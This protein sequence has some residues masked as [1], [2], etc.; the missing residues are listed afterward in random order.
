MAKHI[1]TLDVQLALH[2]GVKDIIKGKLYPSS[3]EEGVYELSPAYLPVAFRYQC[4]GY[5]LIVKLSHQFMVGIETPEEL[6]EKVIQLVTDFFGISTDDII[7]YQVIKTPISKLRVKCNS[8]KEITRILGGKPVLQDL[9]E[10]NRIEYCNN[11]KML[12]PDVEKLIVADIFRIAP[13]TSRGATKGL[14]KYPNRVNCT[15]ATDNNT[16]VAITCYFK[17]YERLEDGDLEGAEKYK[18][19]LRSEVKL[20]NAHLNYMKG[21]RDKTL[22]NYFKEDVAQEYFTKYLAPIFSTEP[23]YRVD[24]ALDMIENY[25]PQSDEDIVVTDLEKKR[26]CA[27][28]IEI[29]QNGISAV[30]TKHDDKT[31]KK[32]ISIVRRLGINPICYSELIDG[33]V[34]TIEK[35][36]NFTLFSNSISEDI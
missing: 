2:T 31:F 26:A 18:G 24:V 14:W 9:V 1:D 20:K 30:K 6:Q 29:N 16:H 11:T 33:Q 17:E 19:C 7:Q 36:K 8:G 28:I 23:F 3:D 5:Y 15:Y 25:E 4:R 22:R 35:M 27:F 10:I 12:N 34:I 13:E 32:Y 21:S